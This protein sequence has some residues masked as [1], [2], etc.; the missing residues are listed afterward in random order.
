MHKDIKQQL[1]FL[2]ETD[3]LKG[4]ERRTSPIGQTRRENSAEHSWQVALAALLFADHASQEIDLLRVLKMLLIHDIPEVDVGDVF[5]Y[6]KDSTDGLHAR[7][8]AATERLC[9]LLPASQRAALLG[10]WDEFEARET[11]A[12]RYA[13]AVDRFMAFVM[14][15]NN[16]GGTWVEH[17]LSARQVLDKNAHVREGS[18]A[19][20]EALEEI[21]A[22]A[23]AAGHL[24]PR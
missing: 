21:V 18:V 15:A 10:L 7:E 11:P 23:E 2:I 9:A 4:V 13:A 16:D 17:A 1:Q 19:L 8:R 22:A 24:A 6:D 12:A 14:N 3:A 5:H 20:W